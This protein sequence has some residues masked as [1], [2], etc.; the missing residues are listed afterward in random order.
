VPIT[1]EPIVA[2]GGTVTLTGVA[3]PTGAAPSSATAFLAGF[4]ERGAANTPVPFT[5]LG[6]YQA[7][8]GPRTGSSATLW[9][10]VDVACQE[11]QGAASGYFARV[12]GPAAV[13]ALLNDPDTLGVNTVRVAAAWPGASGQQLLRQWTAG[14]IAGTVSLIIFDTAVSTVTPVEVYRNLP[15]IPTIV[16]TVNA[17]SQLVV[18]IDLASTSAGAARLPAVNASPAALAGGA[19]DRASAGDAQ[20]ATAVNSFTSDLGSGVML[21]PGRATPAMHAT[22]AAASLL[23]YRVALGDGPDQPG[24]ADLTAL[25]VADSVLP[26]YLTNGDSIIPVGPWVVAPA[27][28]GTAVPRYV[29]ASAASAGLIARNDLAAGHA[30]RASLGRHGSLGYCTGIHSTLGEGDRD[31]ID[32]GPGLP[33]ASFIRST[34]ATPAQAMGFRTASADPTF[35]YDAAGMR[36]TA[37]TQYN[38]K[39]IADSYI[40]SQIDGQGSTFKALQGD[41]DAWLTNEW[42]LGALFGATKSTAFAL[43]TSPAVNTPS[44]IAAYQIN[45]RGWFKVTNTGFRV[46]I[47]E[48][49]R[50]IAA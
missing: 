6:S 48:T 17:V 47:A 12:V 26:G 43:D 32:R 42:N 35:G 21:A 34:R 10:S 29:P 27:N 1:A 11:G 38:L 3:G 20:W 31:A 5:D 41:A 36:E 37:W 9:D 24:V 50:G 44:T 19:D 4:A 8:A 40:G 33:G 23:T 49:R 30:R 18:L 45:M 28:G 2:P 39:R 16:S 46:N 15:D 7:K 22:L 13:P 14:T 25:A